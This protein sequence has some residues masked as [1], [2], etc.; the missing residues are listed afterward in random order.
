MNFLSLHLLAPAPARRL[1][2][3]LPA[4]LPTCLPAAYGMPACQ[5]ASLSQRVATV[6][7]S[8]I[9]LS[10]CLPVNGKRPNELLSYQATEV[11]RYSLRYSSTQ[12]HLLPTIPYHTLVWCRGLGLRV[13]G[14]VAV[15]CV[16][17]RCVVVLHFEVV[18]MLTFYS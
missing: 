11:L 9:T 4:S 2:V 17:F 6:C 18:V 15:V 10:E 14:G 8:P 12:P 7:P 5:L 1:L 16:A 13:C 3:S